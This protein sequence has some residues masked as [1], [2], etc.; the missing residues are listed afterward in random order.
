MSSNVRKPWF[1]AVSVVTI[2]AAIAFTIILEHSSGISVN[3]S[4]CI[5]SAISLEGGPILGA[6]G[7]DGDEFQLR[8]SGSGY[9]TFSGYPVW[10][11]FNDKGVELTNGTSVFPASDLFGG[12]GVSLSAKIVRLEESSPVSTGFEYYYMQGT[13]YEDQNPLSCMVSYGS[14]ELP[15]ANGNTLTLMR[16]PLGRLT[17]NYCLTSSNLTVTSIE[18]TPWPHQTV[19][20]EPTPPDAIRVRASWR[21]AS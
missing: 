13:K 11:F 20:I 16:I 17:L 4:G 1:A 6:A 5:A 2:V 8:Y 9:C 12:P 7:T 10:N 18:P 19:E 15:L 21:H 14:L 3:S